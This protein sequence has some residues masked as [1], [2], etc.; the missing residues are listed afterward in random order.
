[1]MRKA[2]SKATPVQVY[3]T[4]HTVKR[5]IRH[6]QLAGKTRGAGPHEGMLETSQEAMFDLQCEGN[7][8]QAVAG[9]PQHGEIHA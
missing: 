7:W 2:D 4:G 6:G 5:R 1:M 3:L 9:H 8:V